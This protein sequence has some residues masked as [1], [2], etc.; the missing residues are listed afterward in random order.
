MRSKKL[1]QAARGSVEYIDRS[2]L[3]RPT[4]YV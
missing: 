2:I 4:L 3:D 1:T